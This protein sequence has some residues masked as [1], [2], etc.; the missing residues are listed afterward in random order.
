L[1]PICH[2]GFHTLSWSIDTCFRLMLGET[3]GYMDILTTAN[4][5][6]GVVFYYVFMFVVFFILLNILLA[7]LVDAYVTVKKQADPHDHGRH[8]R[9]GGRLCANSR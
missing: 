8:L 5:T 2:Q 6:S 4:S 9:H 3:D 7:I 1:D